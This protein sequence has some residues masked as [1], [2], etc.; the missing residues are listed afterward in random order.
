MQRFFANVSAQLLSE[1]RLA[2][3]WL[4]NRHWGEAGRYTEASSD[5][6]WIP[7]YPNA[8]PA[9]PGSSAMAMT[10]ATSAT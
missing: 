2:N 4:S 5:G 3:D 8:S 1:A 7:I 6:S 10:S 9:R